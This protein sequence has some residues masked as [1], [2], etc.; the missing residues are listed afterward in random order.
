LFDLVKPPL[1]VVRQPVREL[2]QTSAE[3]LFSLLQVENR[4]KRP[5]AKTILPVELVLRQSCDC[6]A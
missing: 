4:T 6:S 3:M 5:A 1:T 2:G